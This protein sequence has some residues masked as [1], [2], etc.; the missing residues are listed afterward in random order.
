MTLVG[1][2]NIPIEAHKIILSAHSTVFEHALNENQSVP[3]LH[4]KGF[5]YQD[6]HSLMQY[7]Y[8]G[9]VSVPLARSNELLRMAK[10]LKISQL[11][12]ECNVSEK[13]LNV[14]FSLIP[15]DIG[16]GKD[17]VKTENDGELTIQSTSAEVLN[18]NDDYFDKEE[19]GTPQSVYDSLIL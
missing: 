9:E 14:I 5:N 16:P 15:K 1:D 19:D 8:L 13:K 6:L 11:G 18:L 4:C 17:L 3:I 2:D 7:M 10:Y 12:D